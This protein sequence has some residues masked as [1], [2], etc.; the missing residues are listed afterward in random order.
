MVRGCSA[1]FSYFVVLK[2]NLLTSILKVNQ[3]IFIYQ[4]ETL[5]TYPFSELKTFGIF[6]VNPSSF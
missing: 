6:I 1:K 3:C 4:N 5:I 2:V